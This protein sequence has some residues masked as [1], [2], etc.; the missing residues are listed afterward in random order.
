MAVTL[1]LNNK[2]TGRRKPYAVQERCDIM[3]A[4]ALMYR[5]IDTHAHLEEIENLEETLVRAK[6]AGLTTIIAMGQDVKTN[7]KTLEIAGKYPGFVY[8]ALGWHPW[9][10]KEPDIDANLDFIKANIDK[11]VAIGEVGL[12]YH[13]RVREGAEKDLQKRVL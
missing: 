13:K 12:D 4:E 8:S 7:T 6:E 1:L 3:V 10:I 9:Y 5:L 11:A 2:Q